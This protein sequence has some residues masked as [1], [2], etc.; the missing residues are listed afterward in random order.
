MRV[1]RSTTRALATAPLASQ[2]QELHS[3][4]LPAEIKNNG[5]RGRKRKAANIEAV[6]ESTISKQA[7]KLRST[8]KKVSKSTKQD[9]QVP[10]TT[11][12]PSLPATFSL[13]ESVPEAL[14]P[15]VLTFSFEDAKNHLIQADDRFEHIFDR[16]HC[17]PFEHL[18]QVDPFRYV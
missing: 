15:A 13:A 1:T 17:K 3:T 14:V 2:V 7:K 16:V 10:S 4:E 8:E 6:P 5:T 9:A 11:A 12:T 18:E